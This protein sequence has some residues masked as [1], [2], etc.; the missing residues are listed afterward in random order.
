MVAV[1]SQLWKT[2]EIKF[3]E[4]HDLVVV[5]RQDEHIPEWS[6][7]TF[8]TS[9]YSYNIG[10]WLRRHGKMVEQLSQSVLRNDKFPCNVIPSDNIT[11]GRRS[12]KERKGFQTAATSSKGGHFTMSSPTWLIISL[13]LPNCMCNAKAR[14]K[15]RIAERACAMLRVL[16]EIAYQGHTLASASGST[17][18][19]TTLRTQEGSAKVQA[20]GD[21]DM[22]SSLAAWRQGLSDLETHGNA[23]PSV[24]VKPN[25]VAGLLSM[26]FRILMLYKA[27]KLKISKHMHSIALGLVKVVLHFL[28]VGMS[29]WVVRARAHVRGHVVF[30]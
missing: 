18:D 26:W 12:F 29:A 11:A 15:P 24:D 7:D 5:S 22:D 23:F 8:H 25:S 14:I 6:V 9:I 1:G 20:N 3:E 17:A 19:F 2:L 21:L 13:L 27:G 30:A 10:R 16:A 4:L 28:Q